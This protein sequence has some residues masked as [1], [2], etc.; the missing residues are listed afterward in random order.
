MSIA[1]FRPEVDPGRCLTAPAGP[2]PEAKFELLAIFPVM[3]GKLGRQGLRDQVLLRLMYRHGLRAAEARHVKWAHID[4]HA[5][6][7]KTSKT[8]CPLS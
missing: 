2:S 4:L 3:A 7:D 8:A 1:A 5:P 6:R